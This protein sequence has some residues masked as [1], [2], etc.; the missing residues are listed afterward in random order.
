VKVVVSAVRDILRSDPTII[1]LVGQDQNS[2]TKVYRVGR[3]PPGTEAPYIVYQRISGV[4]PE[5]TYLDYRS[6]EIPEVQITAWGRNGDEAWDIFNAIQEALEI[7]DWNASLTP[8]SLLRMIR[9]GD[10]LELP[11]QD[12]G[13][14]QVPS[15]Y[16]VAVTR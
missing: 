14:V 7:G 12:T 9:T 11:D 3:V 10:E 15:T 1:A 6:I 13:L 16:S 8:Y 5:G 4:R 2:I